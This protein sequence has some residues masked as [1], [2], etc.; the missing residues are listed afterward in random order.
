MVEEVAKK[1]LYTCKRCNQ[2]YLKRKEAETC[3]R[4][5]LPETLSSGTTYHRKDSSQIDG[6]FLINFPT[7]KPQVRTHQ[8]RYVVEVFPES[9]LGS[10]YNPVHA[11]AS[12]DGEF[13]ESIEGSGSRDELI[14]M[15]PEKAARISNS[16]LQQLLQGEEFKILHEKLTKRLKKK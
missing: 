13:L 10:V 4:K 12:F 9:G 11:T 3:F 5:G 8:T 1:V 15:G 7:G 16:Q 14:S 2:V 6:Y